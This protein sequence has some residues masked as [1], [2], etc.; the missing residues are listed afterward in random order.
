MTEGTEEVEDIEEPNW[1]REVFR[2]QGFSQLFQKNAPNF[3]ISI[4]ESSC[5]QG[6][7][8]YSVW[9]FRMMNRLQKENL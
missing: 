1:F 3:D 9:S 5:L 7:Q 4:P 8:N 6:S 2:S